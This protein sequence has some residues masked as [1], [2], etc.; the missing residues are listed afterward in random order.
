MRYKR[1]S[2]TP[3]IGVQLLIEPFRSKAEASRA[4][5][6]NAEGRRLETCWSRCGGGSRIG[7]AYRTDMTATRSG[8]EEPTVWSSTGTCGGCSLTGQ[9]A[10]LWPG[11]VPVRARSVSLG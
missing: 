8:A 10:R 3:E 11:Y 1:R 4:A 7:L 6:R 2:E 5:I 9:S